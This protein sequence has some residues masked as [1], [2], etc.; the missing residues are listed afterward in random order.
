[1]RRRDHL[2]TAALL[3][4]AAWS[5]RGPWM[6]VRSDPYDGPDSV[7]AIRVELALERGMRAE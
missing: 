7:D 6:P 3:A 2:L 1:M 4:L 5:L